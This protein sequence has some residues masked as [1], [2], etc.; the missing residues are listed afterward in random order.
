MRPDHH[1]IRLAVAAL[2]LAALARPGQ[3]PAHGIVIDSTPKQQETVAAPKRLVIRFNSR[4]EKKLCS[5]NLIGPQQAVV[6][7]L[8]Q[9]P[10]TPP[11]TLSYP[12]PELKPGSYQVRWKVLA[13]DGHVTE[14]VIQFTVSGAAVAR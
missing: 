2:V 7:L 8:R 9:D 5:V 10:D 4:L 13:A 12:L 6:L 3:A 1:L 14:G 11:D